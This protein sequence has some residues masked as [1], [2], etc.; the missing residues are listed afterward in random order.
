MEVPFLG[1]G[2][3]AGLWA[4]QPQHLYLERTAANL[5]PGSASRP[6]ASQPIVSVPGQDGGSRIGDSLEVVDLP[7]A[8][9]PTWAKRGSFFGIGL[10]TG[11]W[12]PTFEKVWRLI[13]RRLNWDLLFVTR[14]N[15]PPPAMATV[16]GLTSNGRITWTRW[17]S[18]ALAM[19]WRL[20]S[21][22]S[23]RGLLV[24]LIS[25]HWRT[26]AIKHLERRSRPGSSY[27]RS[28][29]W[30]NFLTFSATIRVMF[31]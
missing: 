18:P 22:R 9:P 26:T 16:W 1:Y 2:L 10:D 8:Q 7:Q 13:F 15:P 27:I 23:T 30:G 19:T 20:A 11:L 21:S 3:E 31:Y 6:S 12:H 25:R 5:L 4:L 28:S 24:G 29:M 17:R 14:C